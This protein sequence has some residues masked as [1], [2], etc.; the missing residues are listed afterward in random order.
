[1]IRRMYRYRLAGDGTDTP[2][3]PVY[4]FVPVNTR[5]RMKGREAE[6]EGAITLRHRSVRE[7][8]PVV[9]VIFGSR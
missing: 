5:L 4:N 8:Y 1:M 7:V 2:G 6:P 3:L 9:G